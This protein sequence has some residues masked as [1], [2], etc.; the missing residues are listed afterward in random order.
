MMTDRERLTAMNDKQ[1]KLYAVYVQHRAL[2]CVEVCNVSWVNAKWAAVRILRRNPA[3][4]VTIIQQYD[5]LT[6]Y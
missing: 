6:S 1:P 2:S 5:F 4:S 3:A